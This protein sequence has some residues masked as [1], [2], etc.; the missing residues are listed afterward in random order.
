[1]QAASASAATTI[2]TTTA[3]LPARRAKSAARKNT[4]LCQAPV[5]TGL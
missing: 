2:A 4:P 5:G 3:I 1:V